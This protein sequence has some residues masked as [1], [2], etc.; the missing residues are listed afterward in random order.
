MVNEYNKILKKLSIELILKNIGL[1]T[2]Q[3]Y[4]FCLVSN[5]VLV[6]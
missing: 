6:I 5:P 1:L 4:I 2:K 3:T